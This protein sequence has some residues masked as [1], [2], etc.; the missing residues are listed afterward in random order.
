MRVQHLV[1]RIIVGAGSSEYVGHVKSI[2]VSVGS[3]EVGEGFIHSCSI[4]C[5][6][7]DRDACIGKWVGLAIK[8]VFQC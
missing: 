4:E 3:G 2:E 1:E 7:L 5:S 6:A 8:S